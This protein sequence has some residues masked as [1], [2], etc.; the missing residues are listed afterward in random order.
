MIQFIKDFFMSIISA[1][2]LVI[3]IACIVLLM[4]LSIIHAFV[5]WNKTYSDCV[6]NFYDAVADMA[7]ECM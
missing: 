1:A 5:C 4:L 7:K 3:P 6:K 2:V